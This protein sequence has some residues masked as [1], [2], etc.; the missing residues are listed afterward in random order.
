MRLP[1]TEAPQLTARGPKAPLRRVF[2]RALDLVFPP[3]CVSCDAFGPFICAR[4]NADMLPAEGPR[5]LTCW[6]PLAP[7]GPCRRC[8]SHRL[9]LREVRS[10]FVYEAAARDAVLA[11]KFRGLS[12]VAPI[13]ARSMAECLTE[14]SPPVHS[15]VPVPL[16]GHRRRLRG[17][18]QSELIA[19]ELSRLTGIRLA[20]RALVRRRST[21]PQARLTGEDARRQNVV[22]AF[23]AV[24]RVPE[25]GVLLIDDV[26]TTGAT[27]D[28]C[29]RVLLGEGVEAVFALTFARED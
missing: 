26:V 9:A 14:W 7:P 28:A 16:G 5:C 20:Q 19:K 15:L 18:N 3:R 11:L 25:G 8:R 4:C 24:R 13:M 1:E 6:M 27:L 12:A 29:A 23:A 21:P 10:A 22:G 2:D 17:Y